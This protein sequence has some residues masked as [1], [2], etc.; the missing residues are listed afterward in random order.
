[1]KKLVGL[2]VVVAALFLM[3]LTCPDKTRHRDAIMTQVRLAFGETIDEN[4]ADET[5][6]VRMLGKLF[7]GGIAGLMAD[8]LL[9]VDN[10]FV[11]SIGT[12]EWQGERHKVSFGILGHVFTVDSKRLRQAAKLSDD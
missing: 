2:A 9:T 11:C 1:M 8:N 7:F 5:D 10:Y 4:Q 3:V 6:D 12:V